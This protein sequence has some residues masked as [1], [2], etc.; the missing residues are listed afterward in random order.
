MVVVVGVVFCFGCYVF[1]VVCVGDCCICV[2]VFCELGFYLRV[3]GV[4][5]YCGVVCWGCV[6]CF[7]VFCYCRSD[8]MMIFFLNIGLLVV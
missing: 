5:M 6:V 3:G 4:D 2:V 7:L 1:V 8:W